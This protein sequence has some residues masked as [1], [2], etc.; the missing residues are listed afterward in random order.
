VF[1]GLMVGWA[2]AVLLALLATASFAAA[3]KCQRITAQCAVEIGGVCDPAT[4]AW[5]YGTDSGGT[6]RTG[7]YDRCIARKLKERR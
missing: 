7:A 2:A 3:D 4:G 1:R 5:R 6:N